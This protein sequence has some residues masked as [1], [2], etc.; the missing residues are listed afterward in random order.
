MTLAQVVFWY[1]GIFLIL[2]GALAVALWRHKGLGRPTLP[3]SLSR[4]VS[5]IDN[6]RFRLNLVS[7]AV[8]IAAALG[9]SA[10]VIV[11]LAGLHYG[12]GGALIAACVL[13]IVLI[14]LV[15]K[16]LD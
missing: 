4:F 6:H 8:G 9:L 16:L 13:A 1:A 11:A 3:V 7:P 10:G 2:L 15:S 12:A 14:G 5:T